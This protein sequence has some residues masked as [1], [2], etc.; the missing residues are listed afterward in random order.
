MLKKIL[1]ALC[2]AA[3]NLCMALAPVDANKAD[4]AALTGI[5]GIGPSTSRAILDE[6]RRG[7]PFRDW[8]DFV[9]RVKGIGDKRAQNL[10]QAGLTV[11]GLPRGQV[12]AQAAGAPTRASPPAPPAPLAAAGREA[13]RPVSFGARAPASSDK[14]D[15]AGRQA[16]G[17]IRK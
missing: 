16:G 5:R 8:N 3:A 14:P 7:G 12:H 4:E 6:R 1:L 11:N 13:A 2:L 10:S 17:T 9:A 15:A